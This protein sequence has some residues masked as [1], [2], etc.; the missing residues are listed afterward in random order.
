M[1]PVYKWCMTLTDYLTKS[2]ITQEAFALEV[3]VAQS[4]ISRVCAGRSPSS[5]LARKITLATGGKVTPNDLIPWATSPPD[6]AN[7]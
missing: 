1:H 4:T 7:G 5:T 3:G 2:G 6:A